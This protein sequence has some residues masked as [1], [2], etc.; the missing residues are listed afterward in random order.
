MVDSINSKILTN[1]EFEKDNGLKA[2]YGS[3]DQYIASQL[4]TTSIHNFD[5][6]K[7]KS[8]SNPADEL[9]AFFNKRHAAFNAKSEE[10]IAL[11]MCFFTFFFIFNFELF[12]STCLNIS[13]NF[14]V[15]KGY[16]TFSK[17]I[18]HCTVVS[19]NNDCNSSLVN[20]IQN[21]H[22]FHRVFRV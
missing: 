21:L 7:L 15:I 18:Y 11:G 19:G 9:R 8:S 12:I 3:Y 17:V 16:N 2:K 4:K 13:Y 5:V 22:N 10:L 20:L 14:P 6:S 1:A